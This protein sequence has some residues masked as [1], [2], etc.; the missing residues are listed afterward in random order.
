MSYIPYFEE[1]DSLPDHF[2]YG[3][4]SNLTWDGNHIFNAEDQ[5]CYCGQRYYAYV[6]NLFCPS[7]NHYFHAPCTE[8]IAKKGQ[9]AYFEDDD[10]YDFQCG[11]CGGGQESFVRRRRSKVPPWVKIGRMAL[12][13]LANSQ[14]ARNNM[15]RYFHIDRVVDF[16]VEHW[17]DIGTGSMTKEVCLPKLQGVLKKNVE[18]FRCKDDVMFAPIQQAVRL[19]LRS[20]T[21]GDSRKPPAINVVVN[22]IEEDDDLSSDTVRFSADR[23]ALQLELSSDGLELTGNKGYRAGRATHSVTEGTWFYEV[24]VLPPTDVSAGVFDWKSYE[25]N[26]CRATEK[27]HPMTRIGWTGSQMDYQT[28]VGYR[29]NSY[30]Y[31]GRS[32]QDAGTSGTVFHEGRGRPYGKPYGVGDVIGV[33]IY[34]P[35]APDETETIPGS[36]ISFFWNGVPQGVAFRN[37]PR[38]RYFPAV[39]LYM[40]ARVRADFGPTFRYP[41]PPSTAAQPMIEALAGAEHLA[42]EESRR[43]N[44]F[45]GRVVV[46]PALVKASAAY[47]KHLSNLKPSDK[48]KSEKRPRS[49][50]A[51]DKEKHKDPSA[52]PKEKKKPRKL[53]D[54]S[55]NPKSVK[56]PKQK[57]QKPRDAQRDAADSTPLSAP[58]EKTS[59]NASHPFVPGG[60]VGTYSTDQSAV[61]AALVAAGF[62]PDALHSAAA[63]GAGAAAVAG[64]TGTGARLSDLSAL[65]NLYPTSQAQRD[66]PPSR[67]ATFMGRMDVRQILRDPQIARSLRDGMLTSALP[68]DQELRAAGLTREQL[69]QLQ[70]LAHSQQL[71]SDVLG[72][73]GAAASPNRQNGNHAPNAERPQSRDTMIG[74]RRPI[75]DFSSPAQLTH[76]TPTDHPVHASASASDRL[77]AEA[78]RRSSADARHSSVFDVRAHAQLSSSQARSEDPRLLRDYPSHTHARTQSSHPTTDSHEHAHPH[79]RPVPIEP[80]QACAPERSNSAMSTSS[81]AAHTPGWTNQGGGPVAG[82]H[83]H[84]PS[85]ASRQPHYL[86]QDPRDPGMH[87]VPGTRGYLP[88]PQLPQYAQHPHPHQSQMQQEET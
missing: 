3:P 30:S 78:A 52:K 12:L 60:P 18:L 33:L 66:T 41:P 55:G 16:I 58:G 46:D 54:A 6:P 74:C 2:P 77:G 79:A 28:P 80:G 37:L 1:H 24:E 38:D 25:A 49:D 11:I 39:S 27:K 65:W 13:G 14:S 20:E 9:V 21:A 4:P 45:S 63:A 15:E 35:P 42:K 8:A 67:D 69:Q 72:A 85:V 61:A 26:G 68:S 81:H 47:K 56:T 86:P 53:Q 59:S 10:G 5:Y 76:R 73:A 64:A 43:K 29:Y 40:G 57:P 84:S 7:C 62:S 19:E 71:A 22:P 17:A 50:V 31:R 87:S 48:P 36:Q 32:Y 44:L 83:V 51:P 34:L 23:K 75:A 70:L 82:K 88:V